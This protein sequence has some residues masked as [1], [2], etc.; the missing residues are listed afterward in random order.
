MFRNNASVDDKIN[1][2]IVLT[3]YIISKTENLANIRNKL[4]KLKEIEDSYAKKLE[5]ILNKGEIKSDAKSTPSNQER[6]QIILG[7]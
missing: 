4:A 5:N 6:S 2:V 3:P 7:K 1:L